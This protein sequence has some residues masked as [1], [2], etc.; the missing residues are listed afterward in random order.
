MEMGLKMIKIFAVLGL[1]A[2]LSAY[3]T[4]YGEM[5]LTGGVEAAAV[6]A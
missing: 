3:S 2:L 4:T 1:A 6:L 5:G